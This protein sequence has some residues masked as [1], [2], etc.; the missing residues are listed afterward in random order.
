MDLSPDELAALRTESKRTPSL[1]IVVVFTTI[2][3]IVVALRYVSRFIILKQPG[4][5]DYMI[6]IALV[7]IPASLTLQTDAWF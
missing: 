3:S 2:A 6:G 7:Y 4:L 1:A 5:D